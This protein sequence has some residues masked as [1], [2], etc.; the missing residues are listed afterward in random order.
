LADCS[1]ETEGLLTPPVLV[2]GRHR[3]QR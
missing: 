3:R 1:F 2:L